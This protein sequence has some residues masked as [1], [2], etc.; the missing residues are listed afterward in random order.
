[1]Q[2]KNQIYYF[3]EKKKKKKKNMMKGVGKKKKKKK[4]S[5]DRGGKKNKKQ[6]KRMKRFC[7]CCSKWMGPMFINYKSV[8]LEI[9][10]LYHYEGIT[11]HDKKML[12][13]WQMNR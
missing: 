10:N 9:V 13:N 12:I 8:C 2:C 5:D 6:N 11:K 4:K 1:M 7:F 3:C